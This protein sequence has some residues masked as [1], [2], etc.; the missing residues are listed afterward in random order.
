[1]QVSC[2]LRGPT[3]CNQ[4]QHF[5]SQETIATLHFRKQISTSIPIWSKTFRPKHPKTYRSNMQHNF[6]IQSKQNIEGTHAKRRKESSCI[7]Q[8][9]GKT[10]ESFAATFLKPAETHWWNKWNQIKH[11][12]NDPKPMWLTST[13]YHCF[14][15]W[16]QTRELNMETTKKMNLEQRKFRLFAKQCLPLLLQQTKKL[17]PIFDQVLAL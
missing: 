11:R 10:K 1:M 13:K 5:C 2:K 4:K 16:N 17:L 12:C 9:S 14:P 15:Y 7:L 6:N 8:K 3:F